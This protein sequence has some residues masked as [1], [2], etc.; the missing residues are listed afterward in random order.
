MIQPVNVKRSLYDVGE[1]LCLDCGNYRICTLGDKKNV[2]SC[3]NFFNSN[4][5][6]EVA[7]VVNGKRSRK[8]SCCNSMDC[9]CSS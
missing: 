4:I 6:Q 9:S 3:N 7:N 2:L 8:Q 5:F 1:S